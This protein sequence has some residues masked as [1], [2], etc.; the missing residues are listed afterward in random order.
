MSKESFQAIVSPTNQAADI[1]SFLRYQDA[2]FDRLQQNQH[3][4]RMF[5]QNRQYDRISSRSVISD[6]SYKTNLRLSSNFETNFENAE[7]FK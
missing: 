4:I 7:S 1:R 5:E 3:S 6:G 2:H